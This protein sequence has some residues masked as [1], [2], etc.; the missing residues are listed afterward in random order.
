MLF[1]EAYEEFLIYAQKR[2][3]KQSFET[4]SRNFNLHILPYFKGMILSNLSV[5]D[6]LLWQDFIIDFNYSNNFNS[7]LY[8]EF[9]AFIKYCVN[10]C[11]LIDNVVLKAGVFKK[12]YEE[13]NYDIYSL[14]EFKLF[15]KHFDNF[16]YQQYFNFMFYCGTRSSEALALK[17]SDIFNNYVY[18]S[19]SLHRRGLRDIDLPKNNSSIR[20]IYLPLK[21]RYNLYKL[22]K[23]YTSIYG[24]FNKDY[25][26]FGG[27]KPLSTTT[28]DR[29]KLKACESAH[30]R[31]ITQHQFRHSYASY[32]IHKGVPIDYVSKSMGHSR[33]STTLDIYLHNEK[34]T[35]NVF[36]HWFNIF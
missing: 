34:K 2:H 26:I 9:S 31:S 30:L 17:F 32:N 28:I 6:I 10:C 33:V 21:I 23:Y 20:Y 18:I 16:V 36:H 24:V 15:L 22:K 19:K 4:L 12:K 25:Y 13:K 5:S 7:I 35:H 11:Y 14:K 8:Y 29:Y 3:K 1:E 27:L